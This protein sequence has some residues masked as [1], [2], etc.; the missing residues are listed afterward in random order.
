MSPAPLNVADEK[1][2]K[3]QEQKNKNQRDQELEDI[4]DILKT[5]QG[6]RFFR[7]LFAKGKMFQ[8]TFTGNSTGFFLEGA[9]NFALEFLDDVCQV[10]P[11]RIAD[12]IVNKEEK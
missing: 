9:R 4:K 12:L 3:D 1:A 7:R 11:H 10:A 8:T 6:V 5:P 2:V